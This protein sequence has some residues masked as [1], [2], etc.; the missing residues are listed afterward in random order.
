MLQ[1]VMDVQLISRLKARYVR[2]I[3]EKRWTELELLFT[4]D[5]AFEGTWSSRG[6]AAFAERLGRHLA[7]VRTTH[8]LHTPEIEV[9]SADAAAAIWP[10]TDILD[11]R[12]EG[13]GLYRSGLG[14][15]H[16]TYRRVHGEWRIASM[17]ITRVRVDCTVF[18]PDGGTREHTCYSQ[19]ELVSW[20]KR[21][22]P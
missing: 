14:H 19:E 17:R 6:G 22:M 1:E 10:F 5:F 15:Y 11:Q 4:D 7:D 16:E 9:R 13:V 3:D 18:L 8:E 20:L 2:L 21:E 12:R